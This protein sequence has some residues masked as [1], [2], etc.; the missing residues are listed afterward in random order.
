MSSVTVE[1]VTLLHQTD[2]A[3]LFA[4]DAGREFWVPKSQV[5]CT[6]WTE[7]DR[8]AIEMPKWLADKMELD[9]AD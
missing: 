6:A 7:G 4:T 9:Y 8:G 5:D 3:V 1:D 2:W